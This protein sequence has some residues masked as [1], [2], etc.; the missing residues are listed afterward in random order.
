MVHSGTVAGRN[1]KIL[2]YKLVCSSW[3]ESLR[4]LQR[5]D[6][7]NQL[8]YKRVIT[9]VFEFDSLHKGGQPQTSG[10]QYQEEVNGPLLVFAG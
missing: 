1:F 4:S 10:P 3:T 2:L 9:G 7:L 8:V 5:T 6:S